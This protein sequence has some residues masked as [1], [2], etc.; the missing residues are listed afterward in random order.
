MHHISLSRVVGARWGEVQEG[1]GRA[2]LAA[3][4]FFIRDLV[5]DTSSCSSTDARARVSAGAG[6]ARAR[7]RAVGTGWW[8]DWYDAVEDVEHDLFAAPDALQR[9]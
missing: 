2:P 7:R 5:D 8:Q 9:L 3:A 4:I 1:G 6:R